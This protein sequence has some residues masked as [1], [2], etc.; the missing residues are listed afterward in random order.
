MSTNICSDDSLGK[1]Y[2]K[3]YRMVRKVEKIDKQNTRKK[4]YGKDVC[5][6]S[7]RK[8]TG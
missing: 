5:Y 6:S 8:T 1:Y 3:T 4:S 2:K 7:G